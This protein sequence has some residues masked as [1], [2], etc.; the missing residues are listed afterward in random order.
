MESRRLIQSPE[1]PF[2]TSWCAELSLILALAAPAFVFLTTKILE[3]DEILAIGLLL[4]VLA[5]GFGMFG[6]L[7]EGESKRVAAFGIVL[8]LVSLCV[9]C[10]VP[11]ASLTST[12]V[13]RSIFTNN[14]KQVGLALL[15]YES[16]YGRFPPPVVCDKRGNPLYSWRVLILPYMEEDALYRKFHLDEPWDSPHN[17]ALLD[18]GPIAYRCLGTDIDPTLTSIQAIIA[19]GS[20]FE[21]TQ[22]QPLT[23]ADGSSNFPDGPGQTLLATESLVLVPW[24]APVDMQWEPWT[25][26]PQLGGGYRRP[27]YIFRNTR[28]IGPVGLVF[29]DGSVHWI[30]RPIPEAKLWGMIT[31]AGAEV[32]DK[33][34]P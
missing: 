2:P 7:R 10:V 21:G 25:P 27:R 31:R 32:I 17:R 13:Q 28:V 3:P 24:S 15:N 34:S 18:A 12:S 20:A 19:P 33:D 5:L 4:I 6:R 16:A 30:R 29:A 14:L 9:V 23:N 22:G 1:D 26:P 11:A 8:S